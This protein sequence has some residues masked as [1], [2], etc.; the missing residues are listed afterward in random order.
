MEDLKSNKLASDLT[1]LV[2]RRWKA[3]DVYAP[4]DLS[5]TEMKKWR[6][7][8]RPESDAF[9]VLDLNPIEEY[10]VRIL[11]P[12]ITLEMVRLHEYEAVLMEVFVR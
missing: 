10:K 1:K 5:S 7:R 12:Q 11:P 3:G 6:K 2:Q 8:G 9:D 4:H